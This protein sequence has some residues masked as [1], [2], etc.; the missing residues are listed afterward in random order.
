MAVR[1]YLPVSQDLERQLPVGLRNRKQQQVLIFWKNRQMALKMAGNQNQRLL[2][3]LPPPHR[4][5]LHFLLLALL[6]PVKKIPI[7]PHFRLEMDLL[8]VRLT[9]ILNV[10]IWQDFL[11][12][13]WKIMLG[14]S[15]SIFATL[16]NFAMANTFTFCFWL[17]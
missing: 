17:C 4:K 2:L 9:R 12:K 16:F 3:I 13:F 11:H 10:E 15:D 8:K 6:I 7:L 5:L 14:K 1:V